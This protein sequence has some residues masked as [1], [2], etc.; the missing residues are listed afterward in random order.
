[1]IDDPI[2]TFA[3]IR[4]LYC[5]AGIRQRFDWSQTGIDLREFARVGIPAS[6]LLGKGY[7]AWINRVIEAKR[8]AE[9]MG[10]TVATGVSP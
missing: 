8:Q 7:D 6:Q 9:A 4:R 1:M 3:D 5:A 10:V 2:I